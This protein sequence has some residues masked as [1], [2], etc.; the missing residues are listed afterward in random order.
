MVVRAP[1]R[2]MRKV[3]GWSLSFLAALGIGWLV[4]LG[5][6]YDPYTAITSVSITSPSEGTIW[7]AGAQHTV[8]CSTAN[9]TDCNKD[10]GQLE[11]DSVT[12]Y[13]TCTGGSFANNDNIGTSVDY[14]CPATGGTKTLTV[15]A[16]DNY[17][18]DNN[19]ALADETATSA[20]VNVIVFDSVEIAALDMFSI[21][22]TGIS[23]SAT[24][25]GGGS[26]ISGVTVGFSSSDLTFPSGSTGVTNGSGVATVTASTG[27][28]PSSSQDSS[29]VTA[30]TQC[31]YPDVTDTEYFTVVKVNDPTPSDP[32][33][34][35]GG[36]SVDSLYSVVL[37]Y[38]VS[39]A[40]SGVPVGFEFQNGGGQGSPRERNASLESPDSSTN[41]SG[42]A[43]VRVRS[44]DM[45][46]TVTVKCTYQESYGSTGVTFEGI[47]GCSGYD[48]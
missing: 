22:K 9:D 4:V 43:T 13:W 28:S 20:S 5:V 27:S 18:A 17:A 37:T 39:P 32:K 29:S 8:G 10:T 47:T 41:A 40:I 42:Q 25:T 23:V 7:C 15:Y 30:T 1:K 21:N 6:E 24:V 48:E 11:D 12:H 26:P 44:S 19:A 34:L 45:R 33:I 14:V 46:E 2:W 31:D 16:D 38:T 35:D 36:F 3:I